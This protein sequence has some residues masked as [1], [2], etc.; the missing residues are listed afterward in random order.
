MVRWPSFR[1]GCRPCCSWCCR[2]SCCTGCT[3]CSTAAASGAIT[4][5]IIP[6]RISTGFP[7]PLSS[8]QHVYRNDPCRRR[9]ADGR[10]FAECHDLGRTV[11]DLPFGLCARQPELDAGPVKYVLATPVFH[12]WH[13]TWLEE[14]GNTNFAGTFPIWD[15][16]F[17]TFRMPENE[18]P[19]D[20]GVD[21]QPVPVR[22]RRTIGLSVSPIARVWSEAAP[23]ILI[24]RI[25]HL[26]RT[27]LAHGRQES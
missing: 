12:R 24:R 26:R 6:R 11:H 4:R 7:R 1:C 5:S 19:A 22:D 16:L 27:E 25:S 8:G 21:D 13:H 15:I 2:I 17:G 20:Y 9:P 3:G 23:R 10:H 18:L 14:G